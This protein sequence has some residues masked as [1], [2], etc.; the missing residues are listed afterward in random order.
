M[1]S[2]A[3][4][5][6][7]RGR[8]VFL[9]SLGVAV[10]VHVAAFL[11]WP[12]MP[13]EPMTAGPVVEAEPEEVDDDVLRVPVDA[14][15]GPPRILRTAGEWVQE[16]SDRTLQAGREVSLPAYCVGRAQSVE[17]EVRLRVNGEGRVDQVRIEEGSGT[18]CG[19]EALRRVAGDLWYRWL[20]DARFPAPVDLIQPVS[21]RL[22]P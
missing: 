5:Y 3:A 18:T 12:E 4:A 10:A 11:F 8:R 7:A 9:W 16:P 20:P 19:D 2:R 14:R 1:E 21:L 15:F 17:G 13:V 22:G 6:R